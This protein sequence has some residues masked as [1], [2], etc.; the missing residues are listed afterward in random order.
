VPR[1]WHPMF[2]FF[3]FISNMK[4]FMMDA[5]P[6]EVDLVEGYTPAKT[7]LPPGH[8]TQAANSDS[9]IA[10]PAPAAA[11]PKLSG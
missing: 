4:P 5:A 8:A 6:W 9:K 11:D 2:G 10:P 3:S 7:P 1:S